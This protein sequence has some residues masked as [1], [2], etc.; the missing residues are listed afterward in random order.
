MS[1]T[2]GKLALGIYVSDLHGQRIR[3]DTAI[4]RYLIYMLGQL[5]FIG[6]VVSILMIFTDP[7]RRALHDRVAGTLVV[8]G[9]PP[10][11]ADGA[12]SR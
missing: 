9:K 10:E 2:L 8:V 6:M 4:L 7:K 3:P 12:S 5:T 1:A 11:L